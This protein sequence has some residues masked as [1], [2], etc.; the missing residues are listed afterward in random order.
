MSRYHLLASWDGLLPGL[1]A[2]ARDEGRGPGASLRRLGAFNIPT[3]EPNRGD[4]P[5]P[6]T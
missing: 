6:P 5:P 3:P 1:L 4:P 2:G